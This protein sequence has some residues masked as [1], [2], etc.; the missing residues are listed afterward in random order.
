MQVFLILK[1]PAITAYHRMKEA[2]AA[3]AAAATLA[4][5]QK[6]ACVARVAQPVSVGFRK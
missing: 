4:C 3:A 6:L 1:C 5:P 2:L